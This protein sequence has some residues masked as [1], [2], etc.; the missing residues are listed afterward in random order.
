M[1]PPWQHPA[2]RRPKTARCQRCK[3]KIKIK[4]RGR[5]PKFCSATCRQLAYERRKWQRPTPIELAAK[6]RA[7][8][9]VRS[10]IRDGALEH[11]AGARTCCPK[12]TAAAGASQTATAHALARS[13]AS[14][15]AGIARQPVGVAEAASRRLS[16][17]AQAPS[18]ADMS[19]RY[20]PANR[21]SSALRQKRL[22]LNS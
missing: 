18:L 20:S 10:A 4:S 21:T 3:A 6:F 16:W 11:V 19:E 15:G 1:A 12:S 2:R 8:Y 7:S 5:V 13:R 14:A 9:E 22:L 17:E